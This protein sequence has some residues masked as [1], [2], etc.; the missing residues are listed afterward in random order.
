M[1]A[2]ACTEAV[3]VIFWYP[4]FM[5][6]KTMFWTGLVEGGA[7]YDRNVILA[8]TPASLVCDCVF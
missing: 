1:L 3:P 6:Q 4:L 8:L 7:L 2:T 5:T